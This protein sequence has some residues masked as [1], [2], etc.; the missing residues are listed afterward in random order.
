MSDLNAFVCCVFPLCVTIAKWTMRWKV[1][2]VK[3]HET[4]HH[5]LRPLHARYGLLCLVSLPALAA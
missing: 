5:A 1:E 3:R 2:G 4:R